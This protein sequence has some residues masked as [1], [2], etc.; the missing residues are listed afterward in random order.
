MASQYYQCKDQARL[1]N[2]VREFI[3]YSGLKDYAELRAVARSH[4]IGW[5]KDMEHRKLRPAS[6]RRKL[7]A[8]SSLFDYLCERNAVAGNPVDGVRRPV[9]N[10]NEGSTP[11]LG[12]RQAR[13]LLDAPP[14]TTLKG[15]RDRAILATLLYHAIRREELCGLKVGDLQTRQG[16]AHFRVMGKRG[17]IR[18][19]PVNAAALRMIEDYLATA[20]HR[21][22]AQGALFRPVRNNRTG[23][24]DRHLDPGSVYRNIVVKYGLQ[25]GISAEVNGLCVHSLRATAATNALSHDSD[26]AKVQEWLGHANISTTRLYDRRKSKPEDSPSFRVKY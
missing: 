8:L 3:L 13:R 5:R 18:F 22:D 17:K 16:V 14:A 2:D 7:S 21:R 24:L 12:D 10:G 1:Q 20:G 19:I 25:T 26:I 9:A 6:I 11:A 4:I 15:I 23:R